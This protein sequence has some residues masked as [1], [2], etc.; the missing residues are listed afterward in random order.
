MLKR[1]SFFLLV[2]FALF[3]FCCP[4]VISTPSKFSFVVLGD[5][6]SNH[7]FSKIVNLINRE[8][9]AFV[10]H[11]GDITDHGTRKEMEKYLKIAKKIRYPVRY[12]RGNHDKRNLFREFFGNS[13]YSWDYDNCHF[14][15]LDNGYE[16][17]GS[18][19]FAW[20]END[21]SKTDKPVKIV[22][23]HMPI[24]SKL[25]PKHVMGKFSGF[26]GRN[27]GRRLESIFVKHKVSHV[28]TGHIHA[29]QDLGVHKGVHYTISGGGGAA[30]YASP[31]NGGFYHYL[32]V[33]VDNTS[34]SHKVVRVYQS[35]R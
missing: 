14:V 17:I 10:V 2:I 20:L 32:L 30:L 26:L 9:C 16:L 1:L 8:K 18:T 22:F 6:Q 11:T 4:T 12:A 35:N 28:F 27:D 23:M 13:Y 34:V 31:S 21:L 5:T 25:K 24:F 15:V 33:T 19:Q 3:I 7:V 29:Y